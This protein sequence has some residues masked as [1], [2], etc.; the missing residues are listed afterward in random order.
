MCVHVFV[1]VR[2]RKRVFQCV[3]PACVVFVCVILSLHPSI[4][5]LWHLA[6]LPLYLTI[7]WGKHIF[8]IRNP[9]VTFCV[10][11]WGCWY[12]L[13]WGR[14][15]HRCERT[16]LFLALVLL[17]VDV[18]VCVFSS[19]S[20]CKSN[21]VYLGL[22]NFA[23]VCSMSRV[24]MDMSFAQTH[25]NTLLTRMLSGQWGLQWC[26]ASW[27][28]PLSLLLPAVQRVIFNQLSPLH[29][30][31]M[32]HR[33]IA[34][35]LLPPSHFIF[36]FI[37]SLVTGGGDNRCKAN[38]W[39]A[40]PPSSLFLFSFQQKDYPP[41]SP[42]LFFPCFF[43]A[44]LVCLFIFIT[45]LAFYHIPPLLSL[46]W[47]FSLLHREGF[48]VDAS[49]SWQWVRHIYSRQLEIT[50]MYSIGSL[51]CWTIAYWIFLWPNLCL[52]IHPP[53]LT[54]GF[55]R[56]MCIQNNCEPNKNRMFGM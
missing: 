40:Y 8:P 26:P 50:K 39:V 48:L 36:I 56:S 53:Y 37:L 46:S 14:E 18:C 29:P 45:L 17:C 23:F 31:S 2:V 3:L 19:P 35:T 22:H 54:L 11:G 6:V 10:G 28:Y 27:K 49:S 13:W 1:W 7:I 38:L 52:F 55:K 41:F 5:H 16:H 25:I 34:P 43:F 42:S 51:S 15:I 12:F 9:V 21:C 24:V 30:L 47:Y 32:L 33:A 44:L 4:Y 20:V